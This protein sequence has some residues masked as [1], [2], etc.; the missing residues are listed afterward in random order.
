MSSAYPPSGGASAREC[1]HCGMFLPPNEVS[2]R[3][4]GYS[5]A[6][7]QESN[8]AGSVPAMASWGRMPPTSSGSPSRD[9][10]Q[11]RGQP[12]P[13]APTMQNMFSGQPPVPQLSLGRS[14][15]ALPRETIPPEQSVQ[16]LQKSVK[17]GKN[18]QNQIPVLDGIRAVACLSVLSFHLNQVT[19]ALHGINNYLAALAYFGESGVILFFLLSGFLLFLPYA[20]ALLFDSAW[21]S[22]YR[23]YLRRIFRILPGYF[24]ALF[25]FVLFFHPEYMQLQFFLFALNFRATEVV[26]PAFWTLAVEML[27]YTLLPLLAWIFRVVVGRGPVGWR[28]LKLIVCLLVMVAWGMLSQYWGLYIAQTSQLDFFIPH[29][30]SSALL[31]LIHGDKGNFA[32]VFAMGMLLCVVYTFTHYA[33]PGTSWGVRISRLTPLMWIGGLAVVAFLSLCHLYAVRTFVRIDSATIFPFLDPYASSIGYYWPFYQSL[34]Y[35]VGYGLCMGA[36]VYGSPASKRV[37]E[38]SLVRALGSISFS[39]YLWHLP[40]LF[41]FADAVAPTLADNGLGSPVVYLALWC[42]AI[43]IILPVSVFVYRSVEKPGISFG[44]WGEQTAGLF[45]SQKRAKQEANSSQG[46]RERT[47]SEEKRAAL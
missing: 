15:V 21:P 14:T 20:K 38:C 1:Q 19:A 30:L 24:V 3:N 10:G 16:S 27:F 4:C 22:P 32:E 37:F 25:L 41:L 8:G 26:D 18:P 34:V 33:S 47:A 40:L 46:V 45:E 31:P 11:Q 6:P 36:V 17:E 12:S 9:A 7:A 23:F 35:A 2:C 28:M 5:N 43:V 39:L 29:A 13:A 44:R 42:W